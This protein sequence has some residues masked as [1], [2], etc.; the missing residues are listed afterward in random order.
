MFFYPG[1][2]SFVV[3]SLLMAILYA[4]CSGTIICLNTMTLWTNATTTVGTKKSTAVETIAPAPV[5]PNAPAVAAK[6]L[7]LTEQHAAHE[8]AQW[9]KYKRE[10]GARPAGTPTTATVTAVLRE[11]ARDRKAAAAATALAGDADD[12]TS[13]PFS[14]PPAVWVM[15]LVFTLHFA[16]SLVRAIYTRKNGAYRWGYLI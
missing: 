15:F 7:S 11:I 14:L 10:G 5:E 12:D 4:Y 8:L 9:L 6:D 1:H 2:G 3:E 16:F 13:T